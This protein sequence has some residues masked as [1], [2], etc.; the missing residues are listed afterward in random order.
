MRGTIA[1]M[2]DDARSP[3]V[4]NV[5][6]AVRASAAFSARFGSRSYLST[7]MLRSAQRF[8]TIAERI[9]NENTGSWASPHAEEHMDYVIASVLGSANFLEAVAN[10]L[11]ADAAE[12]HGLEG[13]GYLASLRPEVVQ[14]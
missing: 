8:A 2:T 6:G 14:T 10:E 12:G 11:F 4:I 7:W 9:E 1:H 3:Q 13:D 5:T